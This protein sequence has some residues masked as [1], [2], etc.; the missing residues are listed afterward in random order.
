MRVEIVHKH[1]AK[2]TMP[3]KGKH[4]WMVMTMFRVADPAAVQFV[5]DHE[6]VLT[7]EGPGCFL[8]EELYSERVASR[9]CPGEPTREEK[10]R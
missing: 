2:I 8:C 9:P 5:L 10:T 1:N 7:I 4:L 3:P 6:N